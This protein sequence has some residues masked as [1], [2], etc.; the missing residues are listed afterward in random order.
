MTDQRLNPAIAALK[1]LIET[2]ITA[3]KKVDDQFKHLEQYSADEFPLL[4]IMI[5]SENKNHD[6]TST[7]ESFRNIAFRI[8]GDATAS[9][10]DVI[11]LYEDVM[12]LIERDENI[13]LSGTVISVLT[14]AGEPAFTWADTLTHPF[15]DGTVVFRLRR[16]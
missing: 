14:M 2:N 10:A 15:V 3:F 12:H 1:S 6:I 11:T 8:S 16:D 9:Q 7:T 4:R 13:N 5:G